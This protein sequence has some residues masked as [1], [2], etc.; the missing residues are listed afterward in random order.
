M[1]QTLQ[2]MKGVFTKGLAL[3]VETKESIKAQLVLNN[4]TSIY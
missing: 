4:S 1:F 3:T 2:Y